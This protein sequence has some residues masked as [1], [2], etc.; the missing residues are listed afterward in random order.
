MEIISKSVGMDHLSIVDALLVIPHCYC[1]TTPVV[2]PANTDNSRKLSLFKV[3][4][5]NFPF[6]NMT[7]FFSF[8][9]SN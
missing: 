4:I 3:T 8:N 2:P 9:M 5:H 7:C 6:S 1:S